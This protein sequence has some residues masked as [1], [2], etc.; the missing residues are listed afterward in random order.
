VVCP[1][2][3]VLQRLDYRGLAAM[4]EGVD[5]IM[6]R[7]TQGRTLDD[8]KSLLRCRNCNHKGHVELSLAK[9]PR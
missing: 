9:M 7:K 6:S 1:D 3:E 2:W 5:L 8:L 4:H